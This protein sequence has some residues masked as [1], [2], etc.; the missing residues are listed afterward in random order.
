MLRGGMIKLNY[1]AVCF[2]V[3]IETGVGSNA[4]ETKK[5]SVETIKTERLAKNETLSLE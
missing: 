2:Q 3:G 1:L 5:Y 4:G